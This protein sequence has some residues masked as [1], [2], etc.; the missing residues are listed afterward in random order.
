MKKKITVLGGGNMGGAL[1]E[2]FLLSGRYDVEDLTVGT[3]DEPGQKRFRAMGLTVHAENTAAVQAADIVILAV[4]P[5][6]VETVAREIAGTL[7]TSA[8][9]VSLAAGVSLEALK[10]YFGN[11]FARFRAI[12]NI[13]AALGASMTFIACDP[14]HEREAEKVLDLFR[15]VGEAALI[16]EKSIDAAMVGG[17]CGTAYALRFLRA[18][19]EAGIQMGIDAGLS[20]IVAAQTMKG[21]AELLLRSEL[22]P[23]AAID[24]VTTPGGVTIVGLN[25]MEHKGFTSAVIEGH[26]AAFRHIK[27]K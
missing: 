10:G 5:W 25:A 12:P 15:T 22:H 2:G 7:K 13:A 27:G 11:G 8:L 17:S 16:P 24:R 3:P 26:I 9:V 18:S 1:I 6:L 20:R 21:A 4:K 19:M 23:E 14:A